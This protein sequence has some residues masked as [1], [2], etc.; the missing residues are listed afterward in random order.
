MEGEKKRRRKEEK[1][2]RLFFI[3]AGCGTYS[4]AGAKVSAMP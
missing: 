1:K 4:A 2:I 3:V